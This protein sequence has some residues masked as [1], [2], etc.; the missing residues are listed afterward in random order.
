MR[1]TEAE[2]EKIGTGV[3]EDGII[4]SLFRSL[5]QLRRWRAIADSQSRGAP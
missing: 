3:E 2:G 4:A 1:K 5:N